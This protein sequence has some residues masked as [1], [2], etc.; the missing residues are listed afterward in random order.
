M[1]TATRALRLEV[2]DS[3]GVGAVR[4]AAMHLAEEL[5]FDEL[6]STEVGIVASEA[7]TN[8]VKHAKRGEILLRDLPRGGRATD[9]LGIEILALD[10]GPG[11]ADPKQASRD[12]WS[13]AGTLGLGLGA[14]ARLSQR[15]D[16]YSRREAGLALIA[17]LRRSPRS[18]SQSSAG[19]FE[20][21]LVSVPRSGED[22][23]GDA[24]S[25]EIGASRARVVVAD[26]LGHGPEARRAAQLAVD[27]I[28][29]RAEAPVCAALEY[30]HAAL[31]PTRGAAVLLIDVDAGRET[32]AACGVGNVAAAIAWSGGSR[33]VVSHNGTLGHGSP[34]FQEFRFPWP[35]GAL[36][37]AHT[38]GVSRR[39]DLESYPGI[40]RHH[41]GIVAGVIYRDFSRG[42][43]D[44]TAVVLKAVRP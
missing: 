36:L 35:T 14:I 43:D 33:H 10:R 40:V 27:T 18:K 2:G 38:D 3:S 13:T 11:I 42:T 5:G 41:P 32:V 19:T 44:A 4:R 9:E 25:I 28:A 12:G 29:Q 6:E 23:C 7:A 15:S 1:I 37:I 26:G 30:V 39:W 20:V 34:R 17:Q 8:L 16:M 24:C 22:V 31:R 21:G